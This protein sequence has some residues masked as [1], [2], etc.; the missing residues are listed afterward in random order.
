MST[1][2]GSAPPPTPPSSGIGSMEL[3]ITRY[4]ECRRSI[5]R[6]LVLVLH[7]VETLH[8]LTCVRSLPIIHSLRHINLS[9]RLPNCGDCEDQ[10]LQESAAYMLRKSLEILSR[11]RDLVSINIWLDR[12]EYD[13]S[14]QFDLLASVKPG[15]F[16]FD[17]CLSSKIVLSVP[18]DKYKLSELKSALAPVSIV[19]RRHPA[20]VAS[21][22]PCRMLRVTGLEEKAHVS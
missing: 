13:L 3:T 6:S 20:F 18:T 9:L 4:V 14:M 16:N 10:D 19:P 8:H 5:F 1:A 22:L 15:V 12:T 2:V 7:D 21:S 11:A 17:K